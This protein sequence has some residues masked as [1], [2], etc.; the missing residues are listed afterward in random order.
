VG[1]EDVRRMLEEI[2]RRLEELQRRLDRVE[3]I[4]RRPA[5]PPRVYAVPF[6]PPEVEMR[7]CII[8][9]DYDIMPT[10]DT[11]WYLTRLFPLPGDYWRTCREC[12]TPRWGWL[13]HKAQ[14][15][16]MLETVAPIYRDWVKEL[17]EMLPDP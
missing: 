9:G 2:L 14:L 11:I 1:E 15:S 3:R 6:T 7:R 8:C 4:A 5:P 17:I 12:V 16:N 10:E 13:K